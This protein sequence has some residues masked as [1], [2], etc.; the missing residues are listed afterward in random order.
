MI[1]VDGVSDQSYGHVV[2]QIGDVT[3]NNSCYWAM[4]VMGQ[5]FKINTPVLAFILP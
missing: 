4:F 5:E 2:R 1:G 3:E